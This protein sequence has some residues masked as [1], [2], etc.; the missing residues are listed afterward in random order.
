MC[1]LIVKG[2][3]RALAN[4]HGLFLLALLGQGLWRRLSKSSRPPL[5]ALSLKVQGNDT[6]TQLRVFG[7]FTLSV[8]K[9]LRGAV[10][11]A[12]GSNVLRIRIDL[13]FHRC[14]NLITP[15]RS[16]RIPANA[17]YLGPRI[18]SREPP[19]HLAGLNANRTS[20]LPGEQAGHSAALSAH[21]RCEG[22]RQGRE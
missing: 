14:W 2:N 5:F 17:A 7:D 13:I 19:A 3:R 9:Q 4:C 6:H 10:R 11:V 21:E 20:G 8:T 16:A 1:S 12:I 18:R 22:E 15:W